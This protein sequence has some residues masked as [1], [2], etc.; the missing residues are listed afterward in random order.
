LKKNW[1]EVTEK[2][3]QVSIPSGEKKG[4]SLDPANQ[5]GNSKR[6][7]R[8]RHV[9]VPISGQLIERGGRKKPLR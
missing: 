8:G 4:R 1:V 5:G 6:K 2:K 3:Q 9:N 7:E